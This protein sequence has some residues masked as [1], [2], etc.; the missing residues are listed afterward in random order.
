MDY[1]EVQHYSKLYAM[2]RLYED[3]RRRALGAVAVALGSL[4]ASFTGPEPDPRQAE[5]LKLF[6]Q[7]VMALQ[8]ELMIEEQLARKLLKSYDE[9]PPR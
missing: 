6:R 9:A 5:D 7:N 1:A 3:Q 8:A 2:Q 4:S